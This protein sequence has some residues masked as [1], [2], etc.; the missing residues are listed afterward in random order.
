MGAERPIGPQGPGASGAARHG[1]AALPDLAAG[2]TDRPHCVA[3]IGDEASEAALRGG[4]SDLAPGLQIRRGNVRT[5][6]RALER[7]QTPRVLLVDI[8]GVEDPLVALDQLAAVCMPDVLVLAVGEVADIGFY[9]QLTRDL[10]VVEYLHKPLTRDAVARLFGPVVSGTMAED[11]EAPGRGGHVVAVCGARGGV[12]ATTV[13]V[14]LAL[15]VADGTRA[16][17]ALLDLHLRGGAAAMMLGVRPGSGLRVALEE[18]DRVDSLFLDRVAIPIGERLR[19]IAAEEPIESDPQPTEEGVRRVLGMLRQRFNYIV[20]DA[21][22]PPR[23]EERVVLDAARHCL[24]VLGP[25]VAGVRDALAMWKMLS[26]GGGAKRVL[27]VLNRAGL[28][29]ELSRDLVREGLGAAPDVVIPYL[30]RQLPRAANLGRPAL[31]DSAAFRRALGPLTQEVAAIPVA[32][33]GAGS[34]LARLF[35]RSQA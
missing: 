22:M 19:L 11:G 3:F 18:P 10:G 17:V 28:P 6:A 29:G 26:A 25:D 33:R 31:H 7:E 8:S 24:I 2:L 4:L 9:R 34:L 32:G 27:T 14:N 13:A 15:Q 12:G 20:V 16:H 30:P 35:R 5:A 23:R 1:P 21:P